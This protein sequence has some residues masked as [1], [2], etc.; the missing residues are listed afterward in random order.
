MKLLLF[1][2]RAGGFRKWL[3]AKGLGNAGDALHASAEQDRV[4]DTGK[5]AEKGVSRREQAG[6]ERMRVS[7]AGKTAKKGVSRM[8]DG[9]KR[10]RASQR[11]KEN[12]GKRCVASKR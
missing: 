9:G 7:D 12:C 2:G 4:S 5:T 6:K 11:H 1:T 8:G 10:A 3:K